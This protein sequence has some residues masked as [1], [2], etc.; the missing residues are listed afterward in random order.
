MIQPFNE[1]IVFSVPS[2]ETGVIDITWRMIGNKDKLYNL[3]I[4]Y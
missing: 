1:N 3:E 4:S 2:D